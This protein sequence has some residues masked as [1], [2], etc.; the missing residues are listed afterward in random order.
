MA[1]NAD[2]VIIGGGVMGCAIAYNLAGRG[3]KPVVVEKSDIGGEASGANGGGVRQS[4]RNLKEMPLAMASIRLY[5]QLADELGMD[6]EYVRK[7]NLR[8]CTTEAEVAEMTRSVA[9]QRTTGLELEMVDARQVR[10]ILPLVAPDAVLGASWCPTDGHANP[11][12]VTYG[13]MK[14]AKD[15]GAVF[16]THEQV[17]EINL[18]KS[19]VVAV[20]TDKRRINTELVV[21]A[22]GVAGRKIANMVGLDLPM[23]PVFSEAMI[24]EETA[25]LFPQMIGS[26][27]GAYYGRQTVHGS[28]FW[29]GFIGIEDFIYQRQGD[30]P[31]YNCIAPAAAKGL[32]ELFPVMEKLHVL[33]TWSGLIAGMSDGI[34]V[35]GTTP[36]V[37]G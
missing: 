21:N 3:L 26:A 13:F 4:A 2:I 11:F 20:T 29:G 18:Q 30:K 23:K 32:V 28:V 9:S 31:L 19:R 1:E 24:T 10:E 12:L 6:V 16:Y 14:R 37:P 22:A 35:L 33:R 8:L 25:P 15:R 5:G 17:Q 36:E 34:P 27:K 7:G